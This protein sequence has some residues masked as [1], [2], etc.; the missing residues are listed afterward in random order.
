M[1]SQRAGHDLV[2]EQQ[3][4][5]WGRRGAPSGLAKVC[6]LSQC[7]AQHLCT[8]PVAAI[9][10]QGIKPSLLHKTGGTAISAQSFLNQELRSQVPGARPLHA[11]PCERVKLDRAQRKERLDFILLSRF[12]FYLLWIVNGLC[13]WHCHSGKGFRSFV[14][15]MGGQRPSVFLTAPQFLCN[16][17]LCQ[18]P[19]EQ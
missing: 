7:W 1:G 10:N 17:S 15:E 13:L 3:W 14:P 12:H 9:L 4:Q 18:Q 19:G 5:E 16:C 11:A 2:T 8:R 6:W